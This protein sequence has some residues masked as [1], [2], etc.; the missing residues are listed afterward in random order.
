MIT[1]TQY[2]PRGKHPNSRKGGFKKGNKYY[3][4]SKGML[5]KKHSEESKLKIS[6]NSKGEKSYIR[7]KEHKE[8]MSEIKM[9]KKNPFY[10][11]KH[12][13]ESRKNMSEAHTGE[14]NWNWQGGVERI[15]KYR[16]KKFN[17]GGYFTHKQWETL[18]KKYGYMCLCCKRGES[19]IKLT[20]DHIVPLNIWDNWAKEN[21]PNYEGNDIKNIQPLCLSCNKKKNHE[22]T[23]YRMLLGV[24]T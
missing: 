3:L 1:E 13:E 4:L 8:K 15:S 2:Y 18:K 16:A 12:S 20:V 24:L 21:K 23:D 7:T 17:V 10:S 19:A 6:L 14:K 11:K 5:G 22:T 9:G